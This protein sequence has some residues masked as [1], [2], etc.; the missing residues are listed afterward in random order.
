MTSSMTK[1]DQQMS[2]TAG[3][4]AHCSVPTSTKGSVKHHTERKRDVC[5]E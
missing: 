4:I 2:A 5:R 3:T 1:S